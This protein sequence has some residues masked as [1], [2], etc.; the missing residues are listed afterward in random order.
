M[1][2]C[3]VA[4]FLLLRH[5]IGTHPRY[6][7]TVHVFHSLSS[8]TSD[9]SLTPHN[10]SQVMERVREVVWSGLLVPT[11]I[12]KKINVECSSHNEK[13]SALANYVATIIPG[14]T[15]ETIASVLYQHSMERALERIK[16]YLH[17]VTGESQCY[18]L[19]WSFFI[20]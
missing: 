7:L 20:Y 18:V 5:F 2:Q 12:L 10:V 1:F 19:A 14:I 3:C 16:P 15:W 13:T 8:S 4:F 6:T 11:S 9:P 17:I